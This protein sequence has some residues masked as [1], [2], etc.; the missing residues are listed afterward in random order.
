VGFEKKP[1][2]RREPLLALGLP[3]ALFLGTIWAAGIWD[4]YE[5]TV[6]ELG[7]RAAVHVLGAPWLA[8][9]GAENRLPTLGDVGQNELPVMSVAVAF[10]LLGLGGGVGRLPMALWG[11]AGVAVLWAWLRRVASPRAGTYAALILATTPLYFVHARTMQGDVVAM[12]SQI[13][14]FAGLSVALLDEEPRG[15]AGWLLLGLAGLAAGFFSRGALLGVAAPALA[16]GGAALLDAQEEDV[17]PRPWWFWPGTAVLLLGGVAA[18]GAALDALGK[19]TPAQFHRALGAAVRGGRYPTFDAVAQQLGHALFPWGAFLPVALGRLLAPPAGRQARRLRVLLFLGVALLYGGHGWIAAR[20]GVLPFVG[21]GLLAALGGLALEDFE[22]GSHPSRALAVMSCLLAA[23]F[24]GDFSRMPEKT[25]AAFALPQGAFPEGFRGE[26]HG[27]IVAAVLFCA[28]LSLAFLDG[29]ERY[30][31]PAGLPWYRR[32]TAW[33]DAAALL[34]ELG[35]IWQ[36]NLA[37]VGVM[38]EAMLVGLGALLFLGDRLRWRIALSEALSLDQRWLLMNLWWLAPLGAGLGLFGAMTARVWFRLILART[39]LSR[40]WVAVGGGVGAGLALALGYYPALAAQLSPRQV[41]ETYQRQRKGAEPLGLLGVTGRAVAYETG[42][43]ARTFSAPEEAFAWLTEG[44]ERRWLAVRADEL[45]ALNAL[46]RARARDASFLATPDHN[47]PV[48]DA[49][50]SQVVLAS[51]DLGG[52][53]NQNPLGAFLS[54]APPRPSRPLQAVLEDSL[55]ALGWDVFPEGSSSPARAVQ[56]GK[57]YTLCFYWRVLAP[58]TNQWKSFIHIDGH[59]RR[60]NGD[61]E[62]LGGKVPMRLWQPGD[63][64]TDRYDFRL[65]PN[66]TPENYA[67]YYGFFLGERRMAVRSGKHAD[68]RLEGGAFPVR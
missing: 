53:S 45:P 7:R 18:A 51:G 30:E 38:L 17:P 4:P 11:L 32:F 54:A 33:D 67:L 16:V 23:L 57:P 22:R 10:R 25:M 58:V 46:Y 26:Q 63:I 27:V 66:F 48:L 19:A 40:A 35:E 61:H 41:F 1:T 43:E 15:R 62:V 2:P 50:S 20:T 44:R 42:G 49:R 60:H 31:A 52:Q 29:H 68:N 55:E 14:A 56:V 59:G 28:A 3:A 8:L 12:A 9:P 5:L 21:V 24:V 13:A 34:R 37:F 36:G 64:V 47:L 39:G 6:A 65:E